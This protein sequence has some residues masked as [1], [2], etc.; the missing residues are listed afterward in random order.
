MEDL[1]SHQKGIEPGAIT[2]FGQFASNNN[3]FPAMN[4]E[5]LM[6]WRLASS[7]TKKSKACWTF[8]ISFVTGIIEFEKLVDREDSSELTTKSFAKDGTA[9]IPSPTMRVKVALPRWLSHKTLDVIA[10]KAQIGWMQYLRVRSICPAPV[11]AGKL[12]E[13]TPYIRACH[14]IAL[15][16]SLNQLRAQFDNRDLTPWDEDSMGT[17]LLTVGILCSI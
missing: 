10:Y 9:A 8:G 7:T 2:K 12:Y 17:T 4:V 5:D 14:G 3:T 15:S 13:I 11:V 1:S 16:G 6:V